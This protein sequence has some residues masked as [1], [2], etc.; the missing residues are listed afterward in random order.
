VQYLGEDW[1]FDDL[2]C[3]AAERSFV[4]CERVVDAGGL[5]EEGPVQSIKISRL[6]T[7]GVVEAPFGAHF[8]HCVPDYGRDEALQRE[9]AA[10]AKDEEAWKAFRGKWV[11]VP[12]PEYRRMA[13]Q[14]LA[15]GSSLGKGPT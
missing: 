9:Y 13:Q 14:S 7:D 11:D 4:S 6:W 3:Q 8:T 1:Y 12:E 2:F 15:A 10:S 5:L